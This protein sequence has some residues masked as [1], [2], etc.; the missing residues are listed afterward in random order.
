MTSIDWLKTATG[1]ILLRQESSRIR[2]AL[3]SIFGDQFV[4]IGTWGGD[5]FRRFARTKRAT[6]IGVAAD[7]G[8][9]AG[10]AEGTTEG[11][12]EGK[13]ADLITAANCLGIAN[14]SIDIVLLPHVLEA[15]DEKSREGSEIPLRG[16]LAADLRKW[17]ADKLET[18][19]GEARRR[20]EP[21]PAR[22][23]AAPADEP[24]SS[25]QIRAV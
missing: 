23:P 2:L 11:T 19:Q 5:E 24:Q 15:A 3:E 22:L 4:Q 16:D 1:R 9:V 6:V 10:Q 14:D 12:T 18:L 7:E 20:G 8:P 25:L 17:L 21:I 13:G